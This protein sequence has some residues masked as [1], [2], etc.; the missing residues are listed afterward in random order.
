ML[1]A[2]WNKSSTT[3]FVSVSPEASPRERFL[4]MATNDGFIVKG[5]PSV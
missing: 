1:Q 2:A 3:D 5:L 4:K